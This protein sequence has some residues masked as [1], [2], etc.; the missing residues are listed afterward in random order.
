MTEA[1]VRLPWVGDLCLQ[2]GS[3]W[4]TAH[5]V[6][7]LKR[8][9]KRC[10]NKTQI[11]VVQVSKTQCVQWS[12]REGAGLTV[13]AGLLQGWGEGNRICYLCDFQMF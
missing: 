1:E 11:P 6:T 9:P 12:W 10:D 13:T 2:L 5:D 7:R 4:L 8:V 3:G